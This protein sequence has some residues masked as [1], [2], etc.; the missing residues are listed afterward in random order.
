MARKLF[1][2]KYDVLRRR[3]ILKP[4]CFRWV[5]CYRLREYYLWLFWTIARPFAY[6]AF[7]MDKISEGEKIDPRR[8]ASKCFK[9][10]RLEKK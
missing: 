5:L 10:L 1:E 7:E 6:L 4:Y 3:R 2:Y 9:P 8:I